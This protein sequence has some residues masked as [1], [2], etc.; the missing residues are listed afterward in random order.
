MQTLLDIK[1]LVQCLA[2]GQRSVII[3]PC[4]TDKEEKRVGGDGKK[5]RLRI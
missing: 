5:V 4:F 3:V 1:G 2:H